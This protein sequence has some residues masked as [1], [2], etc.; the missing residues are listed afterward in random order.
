[1]I[2]DDWTDLCMEPQNTPEPTQH[3]MRAR[4]LAWGVLVMQPPHLP[5]PSPSAWGDILSED[6][7]PQLGLIVVTNDRLL[8]ERDYD[9]KNLVLTGLG[10]RREVKHDTDLTSHNI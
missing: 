1:M 8:R 3:M 9:R 10:G 5:S 4:R 2:V 6:T 7:T